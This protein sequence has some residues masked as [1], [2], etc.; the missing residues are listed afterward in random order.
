MVMVGHVDTQDTVLT[1]GGQE[2]EGRQGCSWTRGEQ[3][4]SRRRRGKMVPQL[5]LDE[6]E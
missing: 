6:D 2:G 4:K 1:A 3:K 5:D